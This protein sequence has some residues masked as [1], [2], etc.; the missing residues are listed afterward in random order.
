MKDD[1]AD[2]LPRKRV[3]N[4]GTIAHTDLGTQYFVNY[5]DQWLTSSRQLHRGRGPVAA[6]PTRRSTT[7]CRPARSAQVQ[8]TLG[9]D[10]DPESALIALDTQGHVRAMYGAATT[11]RCR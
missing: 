6:A 11:A 5:V 3:E 1:F 9:R 7:G 10:T 8:S 2:V 4:F